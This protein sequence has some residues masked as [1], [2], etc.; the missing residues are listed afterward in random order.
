MRIEKEPAS[1]LSYLT[2]FTNV[3]LILFSLQLHS[4]SLSQMPLVWPRVTHEAEQAHSPR[5][6]LKPAL[7]TATI[8][9]MA[10]RRE[11]ERRAMFTLGE[12]TGD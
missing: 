7:V 3:H 8:E 6:H 4:S 5:V 9:A 12:F 2:R 1:E 11:S 10:R